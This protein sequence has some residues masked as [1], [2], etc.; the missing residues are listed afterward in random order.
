M[1]YA[2]KITLC[3]SMEQ[4]HGCNGPDGLEDENDGM[5]IGTPTSEVFPQQRQVHVMDLNG[6]IHQVINVPAI[7]H[8]GSSTSS[9]CSRSSSPIPNAHVRYVHILDQHGVVQGGYDEV[10]DLDLDGGDEGNNDIE[11]ADMEMQRSLS[12]AST[13]VPG[14]E[15]VLLT[16]NEDEMGSEHN[17]NDDYGDSCANSVLP[18]PVYKCCCAKRRRITTV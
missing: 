6:V 2:I 7:W 12:D 17:D 1:I 18:L 16:D 10:Y 15:T 4:H 5:S 8:A 14:S 11:G 13:T 3:Q 9:S